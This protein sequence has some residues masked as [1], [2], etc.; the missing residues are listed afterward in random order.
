VRI[1]EVDRDRAAPQ[2]PLGRI[3]KVTMIGVAAEIVTL[4][5]SLT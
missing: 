3:L 1:R 2:V 4:C 5:E